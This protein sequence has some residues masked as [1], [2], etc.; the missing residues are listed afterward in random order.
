MF[1]KKENQLINQKGI[2][3]QEDL[4]K[5]ITSTR[6]TKDAIIMAKASP[7]SNEGAPHWNGYG[8]LILQTQNPW[9]I[10][11]NKFQLTM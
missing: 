8:I 5:E 10:P 4:M 1:H 6:A 9:Q 2:L 11:L 7:A 3:N